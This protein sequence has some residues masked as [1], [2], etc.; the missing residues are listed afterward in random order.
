MEFEEV[1]E[2]LVVD[3]GFLDFGGCFGNN[4]VIR[5]NG[6]PVSVSVADCEAV[7]G[8]L[9]CH[10]YSEDVVVDLNKTFKSSDTS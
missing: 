10:A 9:N 1:C 8:I 4:I 2:N 7:G 5:G 3:G 6:G